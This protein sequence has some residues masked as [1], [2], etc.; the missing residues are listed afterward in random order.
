MP[1]SFV[2]LTYVFRS[3]FWAGCAGGVAQ[4]SVAC[5][6]DLVKIKLQTQTADDPAKRRYK[7]PYDVLRKVYARRGVAGWYQGLHV[8]A[9]RWEILNMYWNYYQ[10]NDAY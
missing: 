6:V 10:G 8:M 7:G 3:V 9:W 4:L 2:N 1:F 5:P